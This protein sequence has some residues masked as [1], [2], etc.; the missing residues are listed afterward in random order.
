MD[1]MGE[2]VDSGKKIDREPRMHLMA[3]FKSEK[4]ILHL[5]QCRVELYALPCF[6]AKREASLLYTI[7]VKKT[8]GRM[9]CVLFP[10][11]ALRMPSS[12]LTHSFDS[13]GLGWNFNS[14]VHM[15]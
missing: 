10:S 4:F 8:V 9:S 15:G 6:S 7:V 3:D 14:K 5:S 11:H 1:S 13:T 12:S 2:D